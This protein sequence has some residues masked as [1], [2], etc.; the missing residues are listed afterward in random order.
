[1]E[2]SHPS[3]A[4]SLPLSSPSRHQPARCSIYT[5]HFLWEQYCPGGRLGPEGGKA[6]GLLL[7]FPGD[8]DRRGGG[9][10]RRGGLGQAWDPRTAKA[11]SLLVV[12]LLASSLWPQGL[13]RS[14]RIWP[15]LWGQGVMSSRQSSAL[16]CPALALALGKIFPCRKVAGYQARGHLSVPSTAPGRHESGRRQLSPGRATR[17][18]WCHTWA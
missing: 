11:H 4:L 3:P 12:V 8:G 17:Y 6:R 1:M 7:C 18:I 5:G 16:L 13:W 14:T 10:G 9:R 15:S 2:G